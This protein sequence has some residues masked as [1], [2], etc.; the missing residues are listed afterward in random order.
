MELPSPNLRA[1]PPSCQEKPPR[2]ARGFAPGFLLAGTA[3]RQGRFRGGTSDRIHRRH[4]TREKSVGT[5]PRTHFRSSSDLIPPI[6]DW[7]RDVRLRETHS[8]VTTIGNLRLRLET[9]GR[10]I[11]TYKTSPCPKSRRRRHFAQEFLPAGESM[12]PRDLK[13]S[14][15]ARNGKNCGTGSALT[16]PHPRSQFRRFSIGGGTTSCAKDTHSVHRQFAWTR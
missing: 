9:P 11:L 12:R 15:S 10:S 7:G 4:E 3:R 13:R 1:K 6:S 14:D 16:L 2:A 8:P 5:T